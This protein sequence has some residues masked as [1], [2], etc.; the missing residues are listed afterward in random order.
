MFIRLDLNGVTI[1]TLPV[2]IT[3]TRDADTTNTVTDGSITAIAPAAGV[4]VSSGGPGFSFV[5]FPV[6]EVGAGS[7]VGVRLASAD[8]NRTLLHS[9]SGTFSAS[10]SSYTDPDDALDGVGATN[11]FSGSATIVRLVS[12]VNTIVKAAPM[13][14]VASVDT[15]FLRFAGPF[16]NTGGGQATLGWLG[17]EENIVDP[18]D[19][20][21]M[22]PITYHSDGGA[23]VDND[24][25]EAAG[26]ISFNIMG[27]LDIGAFTATEEAADFNRQTL[28]NSAGCTANAAGTVDTG[29]LVG[30]DG[31][32]LIDDEEGELPSGVD[33]ASTGP[34]DEGLYVL[35][36]NVDV[37]GPE[38]NMMAIPE[39]EYT[40]TAHIN[41]DGGV[42]TPLL[43]VGEET[44]VGV[45]DRD[46]AEVNIPY[47]TTSEKHNQRLIIVNRGTRP[48]AITSIQFTT[49]DG[50]EVELMDTVQ[51]AM[52]AGLLVVPAG[53]SW[54]ARMDET[55][56]ITGDSRRV[57]AALS[58]AATADYISV[59]TTQVNVSD[60]STDTV[61]Y[62]VTD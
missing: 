13:P 3:A 4:N 49:E 16:A 24:I 58:F 42:N 51:G 35:C 6:A 57:A 19:N 9:N 30:E 56:S 26:E 17:V 39:G 22:L 44:T 10:I 61:V 28:E 1:G 32:T 55:I 23:L 46:G 15:G 53:E 60:G 48:A 33:S 62:D 27:N 2:L 20:P 41:K 29:S 14:A 54:V 45:I 12:G 18:A 36:V 11:A 40:A 59:A 37:M 43:M 5:V 34:L 50:T 38:T 8:A 52:D 7:G 47:L 31:M 25:I 21:M